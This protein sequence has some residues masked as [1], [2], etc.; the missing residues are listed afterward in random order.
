M[1]NVNQNLK[2]LRKLRGWT[3]QEMADKLQIKRSLLG[4]YEECRADPR[5][6]ILERLSDLFHVSI[7]DL[8]RLDMTINHG[9]YQDKRREQKAEPRQVIEYVPV[10]AAAGYASGYGD[11]EFI[12]E[13]NTFT[14]PMLGPGRFRAFEISGE[15]MLPVVPGSVVVAHRMEGGWAEIHS[16]QAYVVLTREDG[17]VFK[18]VLKNNRNKGKLTLVS[19]NPQFEP[20]SVSVKDVLELWEPD[21]IINKTSSMQ[22]LTMNHLADVVSH[23]QEQVSVL[24]KKVH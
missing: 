23:L 19:D 22:R 14:L 24:K 13:L 11:Q 2:Y 4:A 17:I 10:K 6:I 8:L 3:Q 15:S 21:A 1:G 16:N 12:E 20:Y 9:S 5:Y 18:R 7:D